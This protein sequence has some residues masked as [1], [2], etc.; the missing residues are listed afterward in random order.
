M[1]IGSFSKSLILFRGDLIDSWL[2]NGHKVMAAAPGIEAKTEL[3][4]KGVLYNSIPLERTGLNP[5]R[6]FIL[7]VY[8][9]LYINRA[10]PEYLFLYTIKPVIYGSL[11]A[12]FA[13]RCN[14]FSMITGLGYVFSERDGNSFLR[15]IVINLYRFALKVNE[16]VFFQNP[17]DLK[18]FMEMNIVKDQD[19]IIIVNGSGVNLDYYKSV[20]L[21]SGPPVFLMIARLIEEKGFQEYIEAAAIVHK[22]YPGVKFSMIAWLLNSG[23]SNDKATFKRWDIANFINTYGETV[24][25]RPYIAEASVYVLPSYREGTPRT[26]LEAMAMGRPIITTDVPGCRE[27]VINGINGYLVP[28]R[29]SVAL[30]EAM[31]R[32][33]MNPEIMTKMGKASRQIAEN[34]YDVHQVNHIINKAMGLIVE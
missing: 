34:K 8:L 22:K 27:T 13:R 18:L 32:F 15:L 28:K 10:K 31:E 6:D 12:L 14:V 2:E 29:D 21:P 4:A 23:S 26:V 20:P 24:D 17:D 5:F 7:L 11:A 1:I 19:N 30:S 16:K 25:V 9:I 3:E 33:V